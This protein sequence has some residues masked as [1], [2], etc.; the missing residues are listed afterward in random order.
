MQLYTLAE[1]TAHVYQYLLSNTPN[2]WPH[3]PTI[4]V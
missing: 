4:T 2:S 3:M 1:K